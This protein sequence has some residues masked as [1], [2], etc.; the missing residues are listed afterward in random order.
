MAWTALALLAALLVQTGLGLLSP[1]TSLVVD[2]F[3]VVVVY[4]GLSGGEVHATLAGL[5]AGWIQD[6]MFGGSVKGLSGL[7]KMLLGFAVGAASSRFLLAGP[8]ARLL[9]LF[10][11]TLGEALLHSRLADALGVPVDELSL[12]GLLLRGALT[13]ALGLFL[14]EAL[15]RRLRREGRP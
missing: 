5:C 12:R 15:E 13:S 9:V 8:P 14:I 11:A 3:L 1:D 10:A 7:S 6:A 2:P 4:C